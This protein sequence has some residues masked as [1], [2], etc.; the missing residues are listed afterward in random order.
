M[1]EHGFA[2]RVSVPK[3]NHGTIIFNGPNRAERRLAARYPLE[4]RVRFR[5]LSQTPPF[6]GAGRI[7]NGSRGGVLVVSQDTI[8]IDARVEMTIEWPFQLDARIPL[9]LIASGRIVRCGASDFAATIERYEFRTVRT[10][11]LT[12]DLFA[13]R[14]S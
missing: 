5:S 3:E 4:L 2:R 8:R 12:A 6:S 11:T 14:G 13:T 10:S 7:V 9:Q 1:L